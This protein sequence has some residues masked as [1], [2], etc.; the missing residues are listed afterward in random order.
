MGYALLPGYWGRG[1]TTS[2]LKEALK[3]LFARGFETVKAAAFEENHASL[4]VMEKAGMH[5]N[6]ETENV[7][8]RGTNH[9]CRYCEIKK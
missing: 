4:R 8:Y 9:L 2:A 6:G 3:T 7:E 5:P 1:Y